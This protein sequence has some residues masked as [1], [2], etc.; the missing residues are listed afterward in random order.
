VT[1]PQARLEVRSP[2]AERFEFVLADERATIGRLPELNDVALE[3]DPDRYVSGK[4][5][6]LVERE[7]TA[8]RVVDNGSTNG[9]FLRREGVMHEVRGP[10]PLADGDTICILAR[11]SEDEEPDYWEIVF[12]NPLQTVP[13]A[14]GTVPA[15]LEYDWVQARLFRV[16]GTSREEIQE[17]R[18]QVHRLLRYLFKRNRANDE[19]PVLC[20]HDDL[21]E[22]IWQDEPLHTRE[23][24]NRLVHDLRQK[25]ELDPKNPRFVQTVSGLGFRLDPRPPAR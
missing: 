11:L 25:V 24:L 10:E 2:G 7:G 9:T 15:R 12:H 23:E 17:L 20:S 21:M 5:H 8:W 16:A 14:G 13:V 19:V 6:C 18:P 1:Q 4:W 22:A 3:P